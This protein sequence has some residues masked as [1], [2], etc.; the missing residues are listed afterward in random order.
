MACQPYEEIRLVVPAN[1][2]L[3]RPP[4]YSALATASRTDLKKCGQVRINVLTIVA[5]GNRTQPSRRHVRDE[6]CQQTIAHDS[7]T[8]RSVKKPE[9]LLPVLT[10][11]TF[12]VDQEIG[13]G[14]TV[15]CADKKLQLVINAGVCERFV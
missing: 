3:R 14:K 8:Q 2:M 9:N 15:F 11:R 10:G 5:R 12:V 4:W 6:M 13:H 1:P 7:T